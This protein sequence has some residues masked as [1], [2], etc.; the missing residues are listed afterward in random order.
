MLARE[1]ILADYC[2]NIMRLEANADKWVH[3]CNDLVVALTY[4]CRALQVINMI[5][6][7]HI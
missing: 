1:E 5:Q 7:P 3:S 6:A 2:D 4:S